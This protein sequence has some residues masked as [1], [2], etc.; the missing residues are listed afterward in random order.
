MGVPRLKKWHEWW[1]ANR[2]DGQAWRDG[3]Q[4]GLLEW[5]S[6]RGATFSVGGVASSSRPNGERDGR[7]PMYDDVTTIRRPT[8]WNSMM[9]ASTLCMPWMPMLA[10]IAAILGY[11]DDNDVSWLSTTELKASCGTLWNEQDGIFETGIGM[12]VLE[13]TLTHELYPLV[14][15]IADNRTGK[16][17]WCVSI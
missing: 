6:D 10:K 11:E 9:S 17:A 4:D 7:Q 8:Q 3:N 2:G 16:T 13:E 14:A 5:G 12:A 15:G 1:L